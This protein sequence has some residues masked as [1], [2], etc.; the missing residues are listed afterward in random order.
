D[1]A[2]RGER[3]EA[4]DR[5]TEMKKAAEKSAAAGE[6]WVPKVVRIEDGKAT[7]IDVEK[8]KKA[9]AAELDKLKAGKLDAID[10][11]KLKKLGLEQ[12]DKLKGADLMQAEK[13]AK[14]LAD[15]YRAAED[16][17]TQVQGR[18]TRT[19]IVPGATARL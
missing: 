14:E 7:A 4:I 9:A 1:A 16:K 12:L 5:L 17:R 19:E 15:K 18:T 13:A 3:K 8:L 2:P 6:K 10:V 11:E